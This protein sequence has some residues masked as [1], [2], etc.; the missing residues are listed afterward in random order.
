[1]KLGFCIMPV[2]PLGH[3]Y[4]EALK[5]DRELTVLADK[6]GFAEGFFGEH[7]TD[8]TERITSSLIFV[9]W[10]LNL[11]KT[12]K[13]GTG[14]INMANHH[15]ANVAAQVAMV[16]HMAEGRFIMGIS[17]GNLWSDAEI[18]GNFDRDR[19]EMLV[20]AM[21]HVLAIWA[22]EP[23]YDLDGKYWSIT[24]RRTF[25]PELGQGYIPKPYQ[26][27]HPPIVVTVVAPFSKGVTEAAAR[28]WDP[29]S[30]NF[31]QPKWVKS[32][33][34]NYVEGCKRAG[35]PA[36]PANWR[37]A[38][39]IFVADDLATARRYGLSP[40][41]P[42]Y[43]YYK[44]I[45][46]KLIAHGR[47]NLFKADPSTP[48][49]AVTI[50]KIVN[51][52]VIWGTPDKVADDILAFRDEIGDFGTLLYASHDWLDKRLSV[53]SMELMTDRVMPAVNAA[54]RPA[55]SIQAAGATS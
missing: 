45:A 33:W 10:L 35:R 26:K 18:F 15:P 30:A 29:I 31:L 40:D 14:T 25:I 7:L 17:P 4:A 47:A 53:R 39:S 2:H 1:V 38:K 32:H 9:A 13:L 12:I 24:T 49:D 5:E 41:G 46:T 34:P 51:D 16:D 6:L 20:E 3:D 50:D 48:D 28:G 55:A 21:N 52:L 19:N 37:V 36:D 44:S 22:G 23:P 11:T 42:Y 27:P 8:A 54:L 43:A